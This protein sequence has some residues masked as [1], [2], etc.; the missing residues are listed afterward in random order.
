M[1][2]DKNF[3]FT[4]FT[5]RSVYR[6]DPSGIINVLAGSGANTYDGDGG[7]AESA[8]FRAPWG[9]WGDSAGGIFVTDTASGTVRRIITSAYGNLIITAAGEIV[10]CVFLLDR[11]NNRFFI[12]LF[13]LD[14]GVDS[15]STFNG[16]NGAATSITVGDCNGV[17]G[18][19][20]G[21]LYV[22]SGGQNRLKRINFNGITT[23][24]AGTATSNH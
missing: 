1:S 21:N 22:G 24:I 2:T 3:Y 4:D 11:F 13:M 9:I 19:T 5:Y 16:D 15:N 20:E 18:D 7:F 23:T 12:Y 14:T 6:V 8:S 10:L 17:I